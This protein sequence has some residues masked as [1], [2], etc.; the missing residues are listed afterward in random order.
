MPVDADDVEG[1]PPLGPEGDGVEGIPPV[2]TEGDDGVDGTP[3]EDTEGIPG[4]DT[5]TEGEPDVAGGGVAQA[6]SNS[7]PNAGHAAAA[8][9]CAMVGVDSLLDARVMN[10]SSNTILICM[11]SVSTGSPC[12]IRGRKMRPRMLRL[13]LRFSASSSGLDSTTETLVGLPLLDTSSDITT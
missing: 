9:R 4:T 5:D 11:S 12:A 2:E 8:A 6:A 10:Q 7:A 13:A 3:G 1:M